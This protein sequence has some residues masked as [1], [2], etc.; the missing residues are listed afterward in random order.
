MSLRFKQLKNDNSLTVQANS[1]TV[2]V[3]RLYY[4][5]ATNKNSRKNIKE[6]VFLTVIYNL[7][8]GI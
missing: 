2:T 7:Y 6:A 5:K 4:F 1:L 8:K 3:R